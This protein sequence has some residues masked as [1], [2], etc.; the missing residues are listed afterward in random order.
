MGTGEGMGEQWGWKRHRVL[1]GTVRCEGLWAGRQ[2]QGS[3]VGRVVR[4]TWG[5][6]CAGQSMGERGVDRAVG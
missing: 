2:V 6:W 3:G 4:V 5:R 1:M